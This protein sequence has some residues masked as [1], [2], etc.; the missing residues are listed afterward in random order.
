MEQAIFERVIVF[1]GG[2]TRFPM[3]CGMYAAME[4]FNKKPDLV[5]GAC[6]GAVATAIINSFNNNKQRKEYLMSGEMYQ[7]VRSTKLTKERKLYRIGLLCLTKIASK[8][9]AH[10]IED[11]F[12]RYLV[13]MPQD[14]SLNLPSISKVANKNIRSAIVGAKILFSKTEVG[15]KR[16]GTKLY[17]KVLFTDEDTAK[18]INFD[19]ISI[20]DSD[21]L[22]SAI[23][24]SIIYQTEA[25]MTTAMRIS[26]SDMFYVEP[27]LFNGDYYA[28]GAI[29]LT[30]AELASCLG[31][32]V[33]FEQ[34]NPYSKIEESLVRAVLGYSGNHRLN[35]VYENNPTFEYINTRNATRIL[36]GH[37]CQKSIDFRHFEVNISL[38][39]SHQQYTEDINHLW[40]CGYDYIKKVLKK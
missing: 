30:P 27:V 21:Y 9:K 16:K 39:N 35:S 26:L 1:S 6:G 17:Q 12:S 33:Y 22:S 34:K 25:S 2:G 14:I 37:Y 3:Y 36:S 10:F 7:F 23:D 11:I 20:N 40:Q 19:H 18:Y 8:K 5:I 15:K 29:D 31:K 13:D 24:R 38:P 32:E 28:G 4:D